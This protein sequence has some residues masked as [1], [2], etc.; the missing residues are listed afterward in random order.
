[1]LTLPN[2]QSTH[3]HTTCCQYLDGSQSRIHSCHSS[4]V[5]CCHNFYSSS[6][7]LQN[8]TYLVFFPDTTN[9]CFLR[10]ITIKWRRRSLPDAINYNNSKNTNLWR[11][12][13]RRQHYIKSCHY[14]ISSTQMTCNW[15]WSSTVITGW[16]VGGETAWESGSEI[17]HRRE[18][19]ERGREH[20][21]EQEGVGHNV[22][23]LEPKTSETWYSLY[24]KS[25]FTRQT[26]SI[27]CVC[28]M[29]LVTVAHSFSRSST[30]STVLGATIRYKSH[31]S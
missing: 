24:N 5:H 20:G 11:W 27:V 21:R 12:W 16:R 15:E 19:R 8:N 6:H 29:T 31:Y 7:R 23:M 4:Q 30:L 28:D 9:I 26:C 1:M 25:T 10:S 22:V 13:F 3:G 14:Y 18:T 17:K 2:H